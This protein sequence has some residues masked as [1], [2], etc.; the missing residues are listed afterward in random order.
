MTCSR[1][2]SNSVSAVAGVYSGER[3]RHTTSKA[4]AAVKRR[5]SSARNGIHGS[6]HAG[7]AA[8][9][10]QLIDPLAAQGGKWM[11]AARGSNPSI[12]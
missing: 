2:A 8:L 12:R 5:H 4:A 11:C 10:V 3:A 9:R 1:T 7:C 6:S